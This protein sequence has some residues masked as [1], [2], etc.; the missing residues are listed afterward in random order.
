VSRTLFDV[1]AQGPLI[2][3]L[4]QALASHGFDPKGSDGLYGSDTAGA[5]RAFQT[6]AAQQPTGSV[7]DGL[8]TAVTGTAVPGVEDRSLQLTS[9]FEG[10]GYG[11]AQGNWDGAWLTWGIVGFTL[12]HGEVQRIIVDVQRSAPELVTAA[13]GAEANQLL[14]IVAASAADQERFA[15]GITVGARLAEPWRTHFLQFGAFP[16]VQAAQRARAHA[17]YFAP[18]LATAATLGLVSELG[19]ALAFDIHVQNG[20]VSAAVRNDVLAATHGADEPT[21]RQALAHAVADHALPQFRD[22][23]RARKLAIARGQGVVHAR[24]VQL[25]NWGLTDLPAVVT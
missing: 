14:D 12:K 21:V 4:Q 1:G 15:T 9:T 11:L 17:D 16:E 13:F 20:G 6:A 23:V 25:A 10:H 22:D 24:T 19:I 5:V 2:V 7:S 8:W 3:G 18:A